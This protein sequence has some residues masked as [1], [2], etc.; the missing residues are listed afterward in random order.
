MHRNIDLSVLLIQTGQLCIH[1]AIGAIWLRTD[2]HGRT[3]Q[4]DQFVINYIG[5]VI[6][7][8]LIIIIY[9]LKKPQA[10][11]IHWNTYY[12]RGY[13]ESKQPNINWNNIVQV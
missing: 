3:F 5:L 13:N 1:N 6:S 10:L 9:D 2:I 11:N 8:Q 7:L 4:T 12:V